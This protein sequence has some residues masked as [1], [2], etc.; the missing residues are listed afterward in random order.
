MP[1]IENNNAP[2]YITYFDGDGGAKPPRYRYLPSFNANNGC[3][4]S[5]VIK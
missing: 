4:I 5:G 2:K 1:L 3:R